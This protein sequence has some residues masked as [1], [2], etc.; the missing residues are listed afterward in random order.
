MNGKCLIAVAALCTMALSLAGCMISAGTPTPDA[1]PVAVKAAP[2][3]QLVELDSAAEDI[4]NDTYYGD[5]A[6]AR[7]MADAIKKDLAEL[8]PALQAAGVP[9]G[10]IDGIRAPLASLERQIG[11]ENALETKAR[12]IQIIKVIPDIY[13]YFQVTMPTDLVRLDYLGHEVALNAERGDWAAAANTIGEMKGVWARLKPNLNS[14]ARQSAASYEASID[15]LSGGVA[16]QNANAVASDFVG[17][18]K[19]LDELEMAYY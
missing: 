6:E 14:L 9:A 11:A 2:P 17:L 4:I 5:W 7:Q 18:M 1:T 3:G 13:D 10:L 8:G 19:K 12:A 16:K 15:A